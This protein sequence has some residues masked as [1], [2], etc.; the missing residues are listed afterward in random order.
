MA[1]HHRNTGGDADPTIKNEATLRRSRRLRGQPPM[2]SFSASPTRRAIVN[3]DDATPCNNIF[4]CQPPPPSLEVFGGYSDE[5]PSEWL[6]EIELLA[7]QQRWPDDVMLAYARSYMDGPAK[8]WAKLN[9]V[10]LQLL[11]VTEIH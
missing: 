4:F 11:Q 1:E 9:V 10:S 6:E 7:R 5:D 8:K 2:R 3:Q